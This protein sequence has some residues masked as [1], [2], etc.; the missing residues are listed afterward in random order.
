MAVV[1]RGCSWD[2]PRGHAPMVAT[3]ERYGEL[4]GGEVSVQWTPRSLREFGMTPLEELAA[5]FDLIV[6]DHPHIGAVAESGC[7]VA[8]DT[9]LDGAVLEAIGRDS[10]GRSHESYHY[11]GHQ[12]GLAIDAACQASAWRADL[13]ARPPRSWV[14]VLELSSHGG[15]LWPLC[16]VDAAASLL[17]L[18]ASFGHEAAR[19]TTELVERN[20]GRAALALMRDVAA[21]SDPQCLGCNPIDALEL[22]TTTDRFVYAPLLFCYVSYSRRAGAG[23]RVRYG[24]IP[25]TGRAAGT[26][27]L[28][29]GAGIVVSA[30]SAAPREAVAYAAYVASAEVQ[31]GE[32][33]A[34]GGQPAHAAAW[35][36]P[37]LDRRAGGFF[38]DLSPVIG[39]SWTRPR[40]PAFAAFQNEM[41]EL[42][43]DWWERSE[44]PDGLLDELDAAYRAACGAEVGLL[45]EHAP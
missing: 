17:T 30:A 32:Y 2:H 34:S 5:Q 16:D 9:V 6:M 44:D 22:M 15:V 40:W 24:P 26:G 41:I 23:P 10:P 25:G 11:D 21:R 4:S 36:D 31:C 39:S 14:E 42:F 19:G 27:T 12:W 35:S 45:D 28:L 1:L 3:A 37:D 38:S 13:L 7:A 29:G 18:A 33:F 20:A 43:A 8:L